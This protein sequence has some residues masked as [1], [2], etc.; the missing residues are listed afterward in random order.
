M[1]KPIRGNKRIL[2]N[3]TKKHFVKDADKDRFVTQVAASLVVF[4]NKPT[5]IQDKEA[6][7]S[8]P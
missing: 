5:S 4:R 7:S 8:A 2:G 6:R 3:E 1:Y